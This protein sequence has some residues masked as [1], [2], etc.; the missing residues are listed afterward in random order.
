MYYKAYTY[1]TTRNPDNKVTVFN[2]YCGCWGALGNSFN[3]QVIDEIH[4]K[5]SM[6][7]LSAA[8]QLFGKKADMTSQQLVEKSEPIIAKILRNCGFKFEFYIDSTSLSVWIRFFDMGEVPRNHT[9]WYLFFIRC[10][11]EYG[12]SSHLVTEMAKRGIKS[13]LKLA[14]AASMFQSTQHATMGSNKTTLQLYPWGGGGAPWNYSLHKTSDIRAFYAG[15]KLRGWKDTPWKE[16]RGYTSG[17]HGITVQGSAAIHTAD[18]RAVEDYTYI[19][20][21]TSYFS[22]LTAG[23]GAEVQRQRRVTDQEEVKTVLDR[24]A[25][26]LKSLK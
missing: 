11:F 22:E 9:M 10:F 4:Y 23:M 2:G 21:G 14:I 26:F 5:V 12:Y 3:G 16:G 18:K 17:Y 19:S 15:R 13:P 7:S 8:E 24:L 6:C 25:D 1:G 20:D